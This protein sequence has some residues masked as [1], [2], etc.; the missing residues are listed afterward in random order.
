MA[1][2]QQLAS[3][4]PALAFTAGEG[5]KVS[6]LL[7][8]VK[9]RVAGDKARHRQQQDRDG[10]TFCSLCGLQTGDICDAA[11]YLSVA[12]A[13]LE[14]IEE[15]LTGNYYHSALVKDAES[16]LREMAKLL[17]VQG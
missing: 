13:R 3:R 17:G 12:D 10:D 1:P 11:K 8:A 9:A 16:E 4:D 15:T 6:D 14:W 7:S 2:D 5:E